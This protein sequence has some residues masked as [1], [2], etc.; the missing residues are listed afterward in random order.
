MFEWL[1]RRTT[2]T[3]YYRDVGDGFAARTVTYGPI[4]VIRVREDHRNDAGLLA[5]EFH[6]V[7]QNWCTGFLHPLLYRWSRDYRL[8]AEL[9]AYTVQARVCQANE[10][11]LMQFAVYLSA[12]YDLRVTPQT[13]YLLLVE[14]LRSN[15]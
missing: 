7:R 9:D 3:R 5:H 15:A 13:A 12:K 11:Q 10:A 14:R 8:D 4:A 6:H 1:L 2:Y